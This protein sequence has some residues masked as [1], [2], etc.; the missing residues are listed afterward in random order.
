MHG[1]TPPWV[2]RQLLA[3]SRHPTTCQRMFHMF[4]NVI[5]GDQPGCSWMTALPGAAFV[6]LH[7]KRWVHDKGRLAPAV[8][9]FVRRVANGVPWCV[10]PG[11]L[12]AASRR[13]P[14][15]KRP[16]HMLGSRPQWCAGRTLGRSA[17]LGE[18]Q[19][20]R[21]HMG[22][23]RRHVLWHLHAAPAFPVVIAARSMQRP[24]PSRQ[25]SP[26]PSQAG[27]SS[28]APWE[29]LSRRHPGHGGSFASLAL[30]R[31]GFRGPG[32]PPAC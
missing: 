3:W 29:A 31:C 10:L 32:R 16:C 22:C 8:L 12:R 26:H 24:P 18:R 7:P 30:C 11:L 19:A 14:S 2:D 1:L 23:F 15:R 20:R 25:S 5:L 13:E 9:C 27:A 4:V 28:R 17:L 6:V 21:A